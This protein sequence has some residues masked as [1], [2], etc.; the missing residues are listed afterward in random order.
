M[1]WLGTGCVVVVHLCCTC[2][3]AVLVLA[4]HCCSD[5]MRSHTKKKGLKKKNTE[6]GFTPRNMFGA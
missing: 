6:K 4:T 2:L 3:T 1:L 5:L